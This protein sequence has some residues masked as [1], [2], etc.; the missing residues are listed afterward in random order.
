M[1]TID[2]LQSPSMESKAERIAQYKA[3]RRRELAERYGST[4]ED[5][6]RYARWDKKPGD[7]S[8]TV[9]SVIKENL[10]D[11]GS[12]EVCLRKGIRSTGKEEQDDTE[13]LRDIRGDEDTQVD[14]SATFKL[15]TSTTKLSSHHSLLDATDRDKPIVDEKIQD[16]TTINI[17]GKMSLFKGQHENKEA[18]PQ[19]EDSSH[20]SNNILAHTQPITIDEMAVTSHS[21]T[22]Q[23][24]DQHSGIEGQDSIDRSMFEDQCVHTHLFTMGAEEKPALQ[25]QDSGVQGMK[26]ILKR[27]STSGESDY[28]QGPADTRVARQTSIT[29]SHPESEEDEEEKDDEDEEDGGGLSARCLQRGSSVSS[30]SLGEELQTPSSNESL[31]ESHLLE[32]TLSL[33]E[34]GEGLDINLDGSVGSSLKERLA[35]FTTEVGEEDCKSK[36]KKTRANLV[37]TPLSDRFNQLHEAE[38]AWRK[39]KSNADMETKMTLADRMKI[40][41]EKEE[42]WKSRGKGAANDSTQFTVAGRMAKR[43]LV[44]ETCKEESPLIHLKK[45]SATPVKLYEEIS[46]RTDVKVEGDKRLDKLESFLDKLQNKGLG[47]SH[48]ST[49]EVTAETEKEVMTLDDEETF[50]R[51]YKSVSPSALKSCIVMVTDEDLGDIQA[52][53]PKLTSA[54]T[55]HK[56][57]V[58]PARK[59][60]GSRN[61]LRAL[62]ARNDIRQ[63]YREQ[64][65]NVATVETKRIQVEKMAKHSNLA[66]AALAGLASKENFRKVNLRSVKST[67]VV[68]NNS[69]LPFNKLM[70]ICI[71]GRRHVQVRLVEPTARSLNSGDC[72]LLVTPKHC[73][74]WSGEFANVIEKAKASEMAS[75]VQAKRDLGCKAPH[76]TV[77]EEGINSDNKCARE[78]WNLLGGKTT[79]RGAGEPEE[80]ELYESGVLDSTGVYK[81]QEDKL[82]PHE[83]A[84][85]SVPSVSLLNSKEVLV[86]DFGSE[87]YVWHGKDVSLGDRKMAVKLAK[88]LYS[89]SYD[90]SSCRVNPL[91]ASSDN[92]CA[93]QQGEG[94][95]SWALLGRFSEHNETALFREKFSDWADRKKEE[96][97]MEEVKSP[98]HSTP[99]TT[100]ELELKPCDVKALLGGVEGPL[101]MLLEGVD[102]QRGYGLITT[103]EGRQAELATVVVDAWHIRE[104]EEE[105]LAQESLG[106]LHEGDTYV[107]RWK[108]SVTTMVGKRQRPGELSSGGAGRERSSC[109]FWQGRHSSV[110]SKGTSALMTVELGSHRGAQVL[111]VQG[112]EPPCFLQLFQGG[113]VI[114]KGSREDNTNNIAAWRVFSVRGEMVAEACLVE[115]ACCCSSLRSRGILVL[116]NAQENQLY[117]WHGCKAHTRAREVGLKAVDRL[118]KGCSHELG[119]SSN[120]NVKVEEILEGEEPAEFWKALGQQDRKAYDCMLQDP[121]KYNYTPRLF[122]LSASSGVF[123]GEEQLSS[124]RVP[125][126]VMAFPFLQENLYSAQQ[127]AI[128]LLDNHMEVYMWQ[129]QQPEDTACTGSAKIRWDNQRKCAMETVLQYCKEKNKRRPPQA[130][131]ILAG[132]EP[133]TFTNIFP[134]WERD[135]TTQ[136]ETAT[137]NKVTLVQDVLSRLNKDEYSIEELTSKPLPE[138]VDPLNLE[139]YLSDQD[140]KD[141]LEMSRV[142]FSALP[143]WKQ[144]NLK[145]SKGL[146]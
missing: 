119:L 128:F 19:T 79:Y 65:L 146:F 7:T 137:R 16:P 38:N 64:R 44:S 124:V 92:T 67:E 138:G 140:F 97:A 87:V 12:A 56:R 69:T 31:E 141:L 88:Q 70:L 33:S 105:E 85:A 22:E 14:G 49:I 121:G 120:S 63:V 41:Q 74:L 126:S 35:D 82:V 125:E 91:D 101:T 60:Q 54:V 15:E 59:N 129:G 144:K 104:F 3:E 42:A 81:L 136:G 27:S 76:V 46:H 96:A 80:D 127:P 95:P 90:Y 6:S 94:R 68:T 83:E 62:A 73:F 25:Q 50:G 61:P 133:L 23:Q 55:E 93:P 11:T 10:E 28:S 106:Q 145:K 40:L 131:A 134:Y 18:S 4:K 48:T 24:S 30:G 32:R 102:V 72:F 17:A 57:A 8:E 98:V 110:S 13:S 132:S 78:F 5:T 99:R 29:L 117:L 20:H 66:D 112:K 115:V 86:F 26:G 1:D 84:W 116:L 139:I 103:E 36:L 43:G 39:K 111:V 21:K 142:E 108:Y 135:I 71:K 143:N 58:R 75:F 2:T 109:F 130:Y 45:S 113:L 122:C 34:D 100:L 118:T 89:G 51:F 53:T 47:H 123:E 9:S 37:Q 52:N 107:I 77:L 114:H